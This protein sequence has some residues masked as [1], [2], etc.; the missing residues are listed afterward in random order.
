MSEDTGYQK[1]MKPFFDYVFNHIPN[2]DPKKA[3]IIGDSYSADITGGTV[4]GIDTCWLNPYQQ[5]PTTNIR[6]TY[7]I[8]KLAQL[9]PLVKR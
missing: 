6:P 4:A 2:F 7:T 5:K 8:E 3:M 9:M 1:P